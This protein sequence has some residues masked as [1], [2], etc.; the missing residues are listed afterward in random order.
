MSLTVSQGF[1]CA[2]TAKKSLVAGDKE[3]ALMNY[4]KAIDSLVSFLPKTKEEPKIHLILEAVKEWQRIV[5]QLSSHEPTVGDSTHHIGDVVEIN[6]SNP[7]DLGYI[8]TGVGIEMRVSDSLIS[9]GKHKTRDFT[10]VRYTSIEG[11]PRDFSADGYRLRFNS[12]I[13]IAICVSVY[14]EEGSEMDFTIRG[15]LNNL[16]NFSNAGVDTQSISWVRRIVF[17]HHSTTTPMW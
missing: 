17:I 14:G 11:T 7:D 16:D 15:I 5:Q 8:P 2:A 1:M 12:N 6:S 13:K 4:R 3:S 10:H 9:F